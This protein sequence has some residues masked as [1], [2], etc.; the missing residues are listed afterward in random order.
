M[1]IE[2]IISHILLLI[3]GVTIAICRPDFL[4]TNSFL[5]DFV[6]HEFINVLAVM[7]TVSLV[8]AVQIHLEY[9]RIERRFGKKVFGIP[10]NKINLTAFILVFLLIAAFPIAFLKSE[11]AGDNTVL[12]ILFVI[13][14][15]AILEAIFIM[16]D[17]VK[18]ACVMAE[19]EPVGKE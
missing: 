9:T 16:Y 18:T 2:Q 10:R 5:V 4:A 17:L 11:F 6:N 7:V 12:S 1:R 13:S 3:A 15:L 19:E 8:S 14:L